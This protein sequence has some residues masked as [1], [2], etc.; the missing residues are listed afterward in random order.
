[1]VEGGLTVIDGCSFVVGERDGGE[2]ALQVVFGLQQLSRGRGFRGIEVAAGAGYPMWTLLEERVG[3]ESVP[4]A[5]QGVDAARGAQRGRVVEPARD[6]F[7]LLTVAEERERNAQVSRFR[8]G[9]W[10]FADT[11]PQAGLLL[12]V[13]ADA[14]GRHHARTKHPPFGYDGYDSAFSWI[15]R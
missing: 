11:G 12:H 10:R 9:F 4:E 14:H 2:H 1:L 6:P 15:R 8:L 5:E 13:V 3:A 7:P